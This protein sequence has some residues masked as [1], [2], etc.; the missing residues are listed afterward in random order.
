MISKTGKSEIKRKSIPAKIS[1][2]PDKKRIFDAISHIERK[3]MAIFEIDPDMAIVSQILGKKL[4]MDIHPYE[5]DPEDNIELNLRMGNDIVYFSHI[6]RVGRKEMT[7][8]D[9]RLHYIDGLIKTREKFDQI[10]FPDL[11][12]LEK[13]LENTLKASERSGL[14]LMVGTQSAAFTA[15]TAMGYQ[16][17]LLNTIMDL[18]MVM[19]L[20]KIFHE[21]CIK[22]MEVF[23]KFPV[24]IMKIGS[25]MV[26][27]TGPMVSYEMLEKLETSILREQIGMIKGAGMPVFFHIDGDVQDMIPE[28]V[29]MGIDILHPIDPSGGVQNIFDIKKKYGSQITLCG[30]INIDTILKDGSP[31]EIKEEVK[32]YMSLLGIGGGYIVSSSHNLHE[33]IPLENFYAMRDAVIEYGSAR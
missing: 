4:P 5:L 10:W 31:Q 17:F 32:N 25:G 11:D 23:M 15:M 6:W 18:N 29:R 3:D 24:D 27:K 21:Y 14:G 9:G 12:N 20:I 26:T 22:E 1:R 19:D 2:G 28:F 33:L 30:N 16:D 13:K 8:K 7:D